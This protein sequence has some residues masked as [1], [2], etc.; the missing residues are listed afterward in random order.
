VEPRPAELGGGPSGDAPSAG[1][2]EAPPASNAEAMAKDTNKITVDVKLD[3]HA[4][5]AEVDGGRV[6]ILRDGAHA[7]T[8]SWTGELE[9][10]PVELGRDAKVA[11]ERCIAHEIAS[12]VGAPPPSDDADARSGWEAEAQLERERA[13]GDPPPRPA[14]QRGD[15]LPDKTAELPVEREVLDTPK[16]SA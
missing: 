9:G 12:K 2:K 13:A 8:A 11:L 7:G 14:P 3:G 4:Y 1:T 5:R 10:F 16:R 15:M 6:E